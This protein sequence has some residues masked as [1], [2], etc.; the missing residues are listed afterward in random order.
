MWQGE[1]QIE[2]MPAEFRAGSKALSSSEDSHS[3]LCALWGWTLGRRERSREKGRAVGFKHRKEVATVAAVSSGEAES[4]AHTC[5]SDT[6]LVRVP[7]DQQRK[8]HSGAC[9]TCRVVRG[10]YPRPRESASAF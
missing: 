3:V 10:L 2:E 1:L 8:W 7:G 9:Q 6:L 5:F 4:K